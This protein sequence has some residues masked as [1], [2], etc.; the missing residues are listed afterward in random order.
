MILLMLLMLLL[1]FVALVVGIYVGDHMYTL[2]GFVLALV[3]LVTW[4]VYIFF[5]NRGRCPLCHTPSLADKRGCMKHRRAQ[6]L[7][8]SYRLRVVVDIITKGHFICPYCGE[9]VKMELR[10]RGKN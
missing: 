9:A 1:A 10:K 3:A 5:S 7:F 8:G 4:V 2:S 6:K